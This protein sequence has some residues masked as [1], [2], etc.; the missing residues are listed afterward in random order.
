MPEHHWEKVKKWRRAQRNSAIV[1]KSKERWISK[2]GRLRGQRYWDRQKLRNELEE[3]WHVEQ[4]MGAFYQPFLELSEPE[5]EKLRRGTDGD[6]LISFWTEWLEGLSH[7]LDIRLCN[8][9]VLSKRYFT[10]PSYDVEADNLDAANE[11]ID[12]LILFLKE[13]KLGNWKTISLRGQ[14]RGRRADPKVFQDLRKAIALGYRVLRD[15]FMLTKEEASFEIRRSALQYNVRISVN[16]ISEWSMF[17]KEE[18]EERVK[19]SIDNIKLFIKMNFDDMF[20]HQVKL[21]ESKNKAEID[22]LLETWRS[23]IADVVPHISLLPFAIRRKIFRTWIIMRQ[24]I[25]IYVFGFATP[26]WGLDLYQRWQ[27]Q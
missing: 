1:E 20:P 3:K 9:I 7:I 5:R 26:L 17:D 2:K 4:L 10:S 13:I 8:T 22:I 12:I 15:V 14:K 18:Y 23:C 19:A 25:I 16:D 11:I 24:S 6:A 27:H 21:L